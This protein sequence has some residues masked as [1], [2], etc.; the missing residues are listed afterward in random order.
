M[1][2]FANKSIPENFNSNHFNLNQLIPEFLWL[3]LQMELFC[4]TWPRYRFHNYDQHF[5]IS[6][7]ENRVLIIHA[8]LNPL[9]ELY[10][11]SRCWAVLFAVAAMWAASACIC[12][13]V[14]SKSVQAKRLH[15]A[16]GCIF[17]LIW[18]EQQVDEGAAAARR[19]RLL[20]SGCTMRG[21]PRHVRH[22]CNT[23]RECN[24][25]YT[26]RVICIYARLRCSHRHVFKMLVFP[27]QQLKRENCSG[28]A[29][30]N[31]KNIGLS[32]EYFV[33]TYLH[34]SW[35]RSKKILWSLKSILFWPAKNS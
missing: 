12:A 3:R 6:A 26:A 16:R 32:I 19:E 29:A 22:I 13:G 17:S 30:R 31:T 15:N 11:L 18:N 21:V 7:G 8:V 14:Q 34:Y 9:R 20:A 23:L 25:Y 28:N 10:V 5:R 4:A 27:L 35:S 33:S 24:K 1:C 2:N